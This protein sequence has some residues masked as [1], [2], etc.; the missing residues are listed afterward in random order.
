MAAVLSVTSLWWAVPAAVAAFL[1]ERRPGRTAPMALALGAVPAA[2]TVAVSVVPAWFPL[3]GRFMTVVVVAAMLPRIAGRFWCQYQQL[4]R[5]GWEHAGQLRR[6][7]Q[8]RRCLTTRPPGAVAHLFM[9]W[10]RAGEGP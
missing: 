2:S 9:S 3:A 4:V 5:A 8:P 10:C 7:S 6:G 1:A